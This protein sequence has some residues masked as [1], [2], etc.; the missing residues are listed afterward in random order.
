[1]RSVLENLPDELKIEKCKPGSQ[2]YALYTQAFCLEFRLCL[3]HPSVCLTNDPNFC[4][5]NAKICE[6][7]A[8]K[9]L[10]VVAE[11]L[12]VKSLDTTWYQLSVYVAALFTTLVAHW[13]RR[14]ECTP[15]EIATL[16]EEMRV[17]MNIVYEI[18]QLV[19]TSFFFCFSFFLIFPVS[20]YHPP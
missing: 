11:L 8:R 13:Q 20:K 15:F 2:I 10:K 19:G 4:A 7:M 16:K 9:L 5:D 17:W 18:G 14:F 3:R 1:M 6:D 12:R